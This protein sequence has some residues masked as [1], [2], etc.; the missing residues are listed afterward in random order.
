MYKK[1]FTSTYMRITNDRQQ[2]HLTRKC[3]TKPAL[4]FSFA[5]FFKIFR[6]RIRIEWNIRIEFF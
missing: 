3:V 1:G 5:L 4:L 2:N 6:N